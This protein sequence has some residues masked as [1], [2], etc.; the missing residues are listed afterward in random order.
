MKKDGPIKLLRVIGEKTFEEAARLLSEPPYNCSINEYESYF[1]IKYNMIKSDFSNKAVQQCRGI[2]LDKETFEIVC[3]PFDKFF[4]Y[5]ETHAAKID[6]D[7]AVATEKIDG[8]L[9]KVWWAEKLNKWMVS[10]NG[11][12]NAFEAEIQND[13]SPYKTFGELFLYALG[14]SLE[15][16]GY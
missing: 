6:W 8:S 9:I 13:A 7:S 1:L 5:G 15:E 10:T 14:I 4:N 16:R 12:V 11:T 3:R 2:I